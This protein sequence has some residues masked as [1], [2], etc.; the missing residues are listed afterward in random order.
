MQHAAVQHSLCVRHQQQ[1]SRSVDRE[2][3]HRTAASND[4]M[5]RLLP[6][7]TAGTDENDMRRK[8]QQH[9][10]GNQQLVVRVPL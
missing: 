6:S 10:D 4:A 9:R 8:V 1:P 3:L 2:L 7:V 5:A